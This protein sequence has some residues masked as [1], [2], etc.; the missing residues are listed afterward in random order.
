MEANQRCDA[1]T[2][3]NTVESNTNEE[4]EEDDTKPEESPS[5]YGYGFRYITYIIDS[6][7]QIVDSL[8]QSLNRN[9]NH[10]HDEFVLPPLVKQ[11]SFLS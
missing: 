10:L 5:K 7:V 1:F 2:N 6:Y 8:V 9:V 4:E 3:M 11:F